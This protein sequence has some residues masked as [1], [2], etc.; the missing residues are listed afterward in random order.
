MK[1]VYLIHPDNRLSR[2]VITK[3]GRIM[4]PDYYGM[5]IKME[6]LVKAVYLLFQL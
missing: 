2:L 6:P 3:D 4:L 5:E 1:Q